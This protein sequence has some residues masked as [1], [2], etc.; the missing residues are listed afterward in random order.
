MTLPESHVQVGGGHIIVLRHACMHRCTI[1][2]TSVLVVCKM[3][4][5]S[6]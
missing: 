3:S 6:M 1:L 5:S 2:G 4:V